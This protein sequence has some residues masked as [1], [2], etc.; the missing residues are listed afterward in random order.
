MNFEL[1][2]TDSF[3]IEEVISSIEKSF[4]IQF[5]SSELSGIK[6]FGDLCDCVINK[7]QST[8]TN[9]TTQQAFYKLRQS[10]INIGIAGKDDIKPEASLTEIFPR[11]NRK[12]QIEKLE[13]NLGFKLNILSH[14]KI[15]S[16]SFIILILVSLV[17]LFIPFKIGVSLLVLAFLGLKWSEN[18]GV[19]FE[20]NT[21]GD[22]VEKITRENYSQAR[23]YPNTTNKNEVNEIITQLFEHQ[24]GID[25]AY[26]NRD[27]KF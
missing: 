23:S 20:L 27:A 26:L 8:D 21:I 19:E 13:N 14:H 24:I 18:L 7:I 11:E 5:L 4:N 2:S 9:D 16:N 22:L 17:L 25:R 1:N 3:D 10:I 15:I 12:I 6:T